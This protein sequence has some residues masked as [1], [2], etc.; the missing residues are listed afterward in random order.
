MSIHESKK[1]IAKGIV[2]FILKRKF[3]LMR[4]MHRSGITIIAIAVGLL[5][6]LVFVDKA[7]TNYQ[8]NQPVRI[9]SEDFGEHTDTEIKVGELEDQLASAYEQRN[10]DVKIDNRYIL[11]SQFSE[12]QTGNTT[13]DAAFENQ[14][15]TITTQKSYTNLPISVNLTDTP[16]YSQAPDGNRNE[17]Y[18]NACEEASILLAYYYVANKNPSKAEYKTD[19]LNLMAREQNN[20]GHHKDTTIDE[21][22]TLIHNFLGWENAY[23]IENPKYLDIKKAIAEGNIVIAPFRGQMLENPHYSGE[24]PEYHVMVIKGYDQQHFITHDVG[25]SRGADRPYR[26]EIIMAAL[27]N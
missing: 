25:T 5:I 6:G 14:T 9:Y 7:K 1:K 11:K 17:P 22:L 4:N 2:F 23:I 24:G 12:N 18:Q 19:L 15:Q 21:F 20:L 3:I 26:I 27:S 8:Y 16:F 10:E 13:Q